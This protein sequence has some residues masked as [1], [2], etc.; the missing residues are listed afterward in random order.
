MVLGAGHFEFEMWE[1]DFQ[2]IH[3]RFFEIDKLG[4]L[5]AKSL[6]SFF[7]GTTTGFCSDPSL[8]VCRPWRIGLKTQAS[9]RR[10]SKSDSTFPWPNHSLIELFWPHFM[11]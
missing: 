6:G 9:G 2:L 4:C 3:A 1:V 8:L 10:G 5:A 7:V 11:G